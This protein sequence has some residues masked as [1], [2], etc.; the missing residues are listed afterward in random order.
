MSP[1]NIGGKRTLARRVLN[2]P[3]KR[4]K[5]DS[6]VIAPSAAAAA[7]A[8][9]VD[10]AASS[11]SP[12]AS[13]HED[14][15]RLVEWR[16][17]AGDFV[18]YVRLRAACQHWRSSTAC[19]RG[20]GVLD[21]RFHPGHWMLLPE[22]FRLYPGHTRLRGRVRFFNLRTG[23][24]A[25]VA[26]PIFKDHYAMDS[27]DG[28]LLLQ[29]DHD[30]AVRLLHP[31]TGDVVE[32]PSLATLLA[33]L[34][35]LFHPVEVALMKEKECLLCIL[36]KVCAAISLSPDDDGVVT[37]MLALTNPMAPRVAFR[38]LRGPAVDSRKLGSTHVG[39]KGKPSSE[40]SSPTPSSSP[41]PPKLIAACPLDKI[42]PP[43]FLA[44]CDSEI[45]LVGR[46]G[47][48]RKHILMYRLADIIQ[49][50]AER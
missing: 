47:K 33:Q 28:L 11:S 26:V 43:V 39:K 23:A 19:P 9:E 15:V 34:R 6:P 7:S 13:L 37:V 22:G 36:R 16:V 45:L 40:P 12:W 17:L 14:L 31:F 48:T 24:F 1:A 35:A 30:M 18:D 8:S 46:T 29:R 42:R 21:R 10:A 32:L 38:Y 4:S 25:S 49:G 44:E 27:V 20:R 5:H 3:S 50:R 41:P 2:V